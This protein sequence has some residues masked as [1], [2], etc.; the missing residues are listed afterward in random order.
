MEEAKARPWSRLIIAIGPLALTLVVTSVI[1]LLVG[2]SPLEVF[3]A[4]WRGAFGT[5][6]KQADTAVVWVSLSI[7][8]AGLLISFRAGQWNIGVEG[9]IVLGSIFAFWAGR[10]FWDSP[11]AVAIPAM[12]LWGTVG[13]T[14]WGILA[15]LL[16]IYG[17]VHEIFGGLGL[18]FVATGLTIYLIAGPWRKLGTS[19]VNTTSLLPNELW[20]PT[21]SGLRVSPISV[22][23]ALVVVI[24]VYLSVRGTVWGLQ[25][26]AVGR[27]IRAAFVLG[28]PTNRILLSSYIVCG[29]CAGLVGAVLVVG[30]RHQLVTN[31]S[32]GYGF[33]GILVVLLTGFNGVL[34]APIALFFA[35]A[36]IGGVALR[37]N[38]DLDSS[39]SGVLVGFV[40]LSYELVNGLRQR[41]QERRAQAT[42]A[43]AVPLPPAAP[44]AASEGESA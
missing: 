35:A 43:A 32:S 16:K 5:P 7:V 17:G 33:L 42:E 19:S 29:W 14:L 6:I 30:V 37:L 3:A 2:R 23:L 20:L 36:G 41:W 44:M 26:K 40:V 39:L 4:L 24:V 28:I 18:N 21:L 11:G 22:V 34:V 1:I 38:L 31:I 10:I 8:S 12:I 25:L 27:N 9:Q 15:G 13:G